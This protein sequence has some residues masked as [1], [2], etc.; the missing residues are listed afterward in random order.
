MAH[1]LAFFSLTQ[2]SATFLNLPIRNIP[3]ISSATFRIS[4]VNIPRASST[5]LELHR[6]SAIFMLSSLDLFFNLQ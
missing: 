4:F 3:Y 1:F 2:L 5:L 6:P